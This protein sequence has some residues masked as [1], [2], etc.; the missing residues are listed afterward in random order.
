MALN[1]NNNTNTWPAMRPRPTTVDNKW[2]V[3]VWFWFF[4]WFLIFSCFRPFRMQACS[5]RRPTSVRCP[6]EIRSVCPTTRAWPLQLLEPSRPRLCS[7]LRPPTL[8]SILRPTL[9]SV[10]LRPQAW[11]PRLRSW[12][13]L[14]RKLGEMVYVFGD[15]TKHH[16]TVSATLLLSSSY[17]CLP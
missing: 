17:L 4:A 2:F 3:C 7:T 1:N 9:P 10:P 6:R 15:F 5:R 13:T 12:P 14:K 16:I 11:W 8:L